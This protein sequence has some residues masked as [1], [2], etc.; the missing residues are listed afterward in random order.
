MEC[1]GIQLGQEAAVHGL[2]DQ[3]AEARF[4]PT[5]RDQADFATVP[6]RLPQPLD[7]AEEVGGLHHLHQP[8]EPPEGQ[9]IGDLC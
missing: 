8:E 4:C 1:Q 5:Q 2:D 9:G 3:R 6:G 7:T